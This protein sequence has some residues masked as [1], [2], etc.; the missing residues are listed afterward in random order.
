MEVLL[1]QRVVDGGGGGYRRSV[2]SVA[3]A[4]TNRVGLLCPRGSFLCVY[5]TFP[6][7]AVS[8]LKDGNPS[9]SMTI[10]DATHITFPTPRPMPLFPHR[11]L[12]NGSLHYIQTIT[13][14]NRPDMHGQMPPMRIEYYHEIRHGLPVSTMMT[15]MVRGVHANMDI[16]TH[17]NH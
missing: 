1:F 14:V 13:P 16:P 7:Q 5:F 6:P 11:V 17:G 3:Q 4:H 2:D 8:V 9:S 15:V 12:M 10:W